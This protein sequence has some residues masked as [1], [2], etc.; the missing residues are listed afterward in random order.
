MEKAGEMVKIFTRDDSGKSMFI[1]LLI[2]FNSFRFQKIVLSYDE[3][4]P[5]FLL[6]K[7]STKALIYY[8][9]FFHLSTVSFTLFHSFSFLCSLGDELADLRSA[10]SSG[11]EKEKQEGL[12]EVLS[13]L[14]VGKNLNI[15]ADVLR[16]LVGGSVETKKLAFMCLSHNIGDSIAIEALITV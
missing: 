16:C 5:L 7:D 6:Q 14:S 15:F 12:Q 11:K 8:R 4:F 13:L 1:L 10:L 3:F 2:L 9:I